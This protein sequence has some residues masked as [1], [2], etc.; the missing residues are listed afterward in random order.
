MT[1]LRLGYIWKVWEWIGSEV[2]D[3]EITQTPDLERRR[4]VGLLVQH[5]HRSVVVGEKEVS[6]AQQLES[7]GI[8]A[9]DALHLACA[10]SGGADVFLTVLP[11]TE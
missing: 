3:W 4:R 11:K 9:L 5:T 7:W 6:R 1:R 10:E 2:I 8:S